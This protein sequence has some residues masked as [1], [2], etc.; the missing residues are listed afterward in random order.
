MFFFFLD[1]PG[2]PDIRRVGDGNFVAAGSVQTLTCIS[3]GGNPLATLT[4]FRNDKEVCAHIMYLDRYSLE[5][6]STR[7]LNVLSL[8]FPKTTTLSPV[9]CV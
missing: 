6:T 1:P 2:K 4:W 9:Q 3:H 5:F 8:D 7:V